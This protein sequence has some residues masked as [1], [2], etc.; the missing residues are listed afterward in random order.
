MG[1]TSAKINAAS[2]VIPIILGG[3]VA[4][5]VRLIFVFGYLVGFLLFF[6]AKASVLKK[7]NLYQFGPSLMSPAMKKYYFMG[8]AIMIVT[9]ALNIAVYLK[10]VLFPP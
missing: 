2:L 1:P 5:D 4:I 8:Y 6:K 9:A 3:I 10:V 7:D